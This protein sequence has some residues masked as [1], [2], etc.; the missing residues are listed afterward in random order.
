MK[1]PPFPFP[2]RWAEMREEAGWSGDWSALLDFDAT[3]YGGKQC[4]FFDISGGD[5]AEEE[6][7]QLEE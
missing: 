6:E 1:V 4:D 3:A 2:S 5:E 7:Q